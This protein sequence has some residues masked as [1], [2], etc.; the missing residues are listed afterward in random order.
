MFKEHILINITTTKKRAKDVRHYI[1]DMSLFYRFQYIYLC[2]HLKR[3]ENECQ[4]AN[5]G[6]LWKI[7]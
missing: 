6:Y 5:N 4:N 2:K 7:E 3:V 1:Y